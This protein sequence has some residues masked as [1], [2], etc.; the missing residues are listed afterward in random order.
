MCGITGIISL[1][2][3]RPVERAPL[4]VMTHSLVHR[5]PDDSG[6]HVEGPVGLGFRRLAIIDPRPI[7]NQPHFSANR[8]VVSVCNGEIF[9]HEDL[10]RELEGR[11]HQLRSRCDVEVL[12]Y[13]YQDM[14]E[15]LLDRLNGQ[16]ALA[17]YDQALHRLVLARDPVGICPLYY[18]VA[19][20]Q[21][22]FA[23]EIKAL[24]THPAVK[25]AVDLTGLDQCFTFPGLVSPNTLFKGIHSLPAGHLLVMENGV[26]QARCYWDLDYPEDAPRQPPANWQ[27]ELDHLLRQAVARRLQSDAQVGFYLS[28]G[29]DSSLIAGLIHAQ[30]PNAQWHSFSIVFDDER[31]DERRYQRM[32]SDRLAS[33]HHEI[34]FK[35]SDVEQRL[36]A[37]IR[38]AE[39]P[40]RESYDTCSHALAQAVHEAGC[41]VV[42][43]G[44]G[45]DELFAG[46]VG[47]R[48]DA[49]RGNNLGADPLD[50]D[51]WQEMQL[52][53]RLWGDG[54]FFYERDYHA[55]NETLQALY[56]PALAQR[57]GEFGA[58][59]HAPVPHARLKR[60]HP[61][62]Q[63]SYVDFKLRIADHLL[64]DHG[65]RMT[66]AHSVEGRYPFLDKDLI[67]FVTRLPPGLLVQDQRE[68]YPLRC[69]ARD[70]VPPAII[71]REKFAFVAPGSPA[72]L[73][74]DSG[75]IADL[76]A[77][78]R[79]QR[80]GYFNPQTVERL[81]QAYLKPG[82]E[83][84]QTF[85][86][87]LMMLV[88]TFQILLEEF[89][90]PDL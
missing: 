51:D 36:R 49:L 88:I 18:T 11:G 45:A 33:I 39:S 10:R 62:H 60:R 25:R 74:A 2:P 19:E 32:V 53:E 7:G 43:S 87:D 8:Q 64:T 82:F 12:P 15:A 38:H 78:E 37:V 86:V 5:G 65:D 76:L 31:L 48:L 3:R 27:Q 80:Q 57:H 75:W 40:L 14:G 70:Y 24:L 34:P 55:F 16:F 47:Y 81:R 52:R 46:Y 79:I 22:L 85:D 29:L 30:R 17:I 68:K 59:R 26:V 58:T 23:S 77:P 6:F 90:L 21:L 28:G 63:R 54:N 61:I 4:E 9:N 69:I 67:A 71:N 35:P 42:L 50:G 44:E 73:R 20:G 72:L 13:L 84:N 83:V 89:D 66:F 1:D 41:K 56:S